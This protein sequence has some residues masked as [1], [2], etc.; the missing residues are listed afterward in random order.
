MNSTSDHPIVAPGNKKQEATPKGKQKKIEK[1]TIGNTAMCKKQ[2]KRKTGS[3]TVENVS[4]SDDDF[5]ILDCEEEELEE[6]KDEVEETGDG[7][8]KKKKDKEEIKWSKGGWVIDPRK[9]DGG[10]QPYGPPLKLCLLENRTSLY[11]FFQFIPCDYIKDTLTPATNAYAQNQTCNWQDITFEEFIHVLG[12]L[13]SMEV[14]RLPERR[15]YMVCRGCSALQSTELWEVHR[16]DSVR[17][18]PALPSVF[19]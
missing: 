6:D 12:I 9:K 19:T 2:L 14:Y 4:D 3:Q 16:F 15:V 13:Y 5:N 17:K 7:N 1:V 10:G 18:N 8:N 11:F